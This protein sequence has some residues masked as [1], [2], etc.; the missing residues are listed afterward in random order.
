MD[1]H[2][3]TVTTLTISTAEI[4]QYRLENAGM[5]VTAESEELPQD[6]IPN[7]CIASLENQLEGLR[8]K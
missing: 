5:I 8:K 1:K 6:M 2:G 3:N 4:M 7:N